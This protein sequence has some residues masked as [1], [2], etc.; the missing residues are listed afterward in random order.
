IESPFRVAV[1]TAAGKN[2]TVHATGIPQPALRELNSKRYPT[3]RKD[4]PADLRFEDNGAIAILTIRTFSGPLDKF[5]P[6]AFRQMREKNSKSLIIDL[7]NNGG[8]AD[9]MGKQLFSFLWD[10]PFQYY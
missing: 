3:E 9:A 8:G 1:R 4:G 7:R 6:D 2:Q 10:Q 5:L